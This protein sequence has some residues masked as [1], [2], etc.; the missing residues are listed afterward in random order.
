MFIMRSDSRTCIAGSTITRTINGSSIHA[1][2]AHTELN[3]YTKSVGDE[4]KIVC[5]TNCLEKIPPTVFFG[6]PA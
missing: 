4:G 3:C 5:C 6:G 1:H 2:Y